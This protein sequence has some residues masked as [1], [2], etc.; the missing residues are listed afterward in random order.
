[1]SNK[2]PSMELDQN[3]MQNILSL[4]DELIENG[5][6]VVYIGKFTHQ[7]IKMFTEKNEEEMES[8]NEQKQVRRRVHHSLVEILQ[9]MQKHSTEFQTEF[10]LV[11]GLFMIGRKDGVYYIMTANKVSKNDI[12]HLS[13]ALECV[14]NATKEEL[15]AMYKKQLREGKISDRGGAGLGLIDIARKTDGKLEYLF[16]P[17]NGTDYFVLKVEI[18]NSED[19][20][21]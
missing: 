18:S 1:M 12:E 10:S 21:E 4:Y 14:N 11:N 8:S 19:E 16:I 3:F 5:I 15:N 2:G 9:N 20:I 7:V 6:S 13:K 17:V